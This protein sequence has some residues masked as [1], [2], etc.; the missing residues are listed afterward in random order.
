MNHISV[1]PRLSPRPLTGKATIV[2][3]AGRG[4]GRAYALAIG[5]AGGAVVVNDVDAD[6]A[7][8]TAG[9]IRSRGGEATA[10]AG[11]VGDWDLTRF[12]VSR[13]MDEF[14]KV[15]GLVNNAGITRHSPPW[16]E[17]EE[18]LRAVA[19]V[20]I[21]GAQFTAR[22]AM[23]AM[24]DQGHGG[25]IINIISGAR[26]GIPG[27]SS[28]GASKGAVASMTSNWAIEG[29]A[30]G[31]RVNAVS[32]L[33]QTRMALT[34]TRKNQ[35]ALPSPDRIAPL[36]VALLTDEMEGITGDLIRF[37]GT[38]LGRYTETL[39]TV[40]LRTEGWSVAELIAVLRQRIS[41][42]AGGVPPPPA[43]RRDSKF[44]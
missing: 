44:T 37:D 14:G 16:H 29:R 24:L 27:M 42:E 13:C 38:R 35:P 32:P 12:L 17:T 36:I 41:D 2:T 22:H 31:I 3:G 19:E 21:L 1:E 30:Y 39:H 26:I 15:D 34:D 40:S 18:D 10:V 5:A 23:R 8:T 43:T 28:Y 6:G 11:S 9:E 33:A 4:L 7:E 25:S 20:N